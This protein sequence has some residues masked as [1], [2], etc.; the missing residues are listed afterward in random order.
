[1]CAQAA[2]SCDE[3]AHPVNLVGDQCVSGVDNYMYYDSAFCYVHGSV[4]TF[5][6][7]VSLRY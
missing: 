5:A 4:P 1:M 6:E 7:R 3:I 2:V